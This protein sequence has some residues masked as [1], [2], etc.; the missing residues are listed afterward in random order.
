MLKSSCRQS[1]IT[2]CE[3]PA[4]RLWAATEQETV[5]Q[6]KRH[7]I[8]SK[9]NGPTEFLSNHV[10]VCKWV[11]WVVAAPSLIRWFHAKSF[12][13]LT[14][15]DTTQISGAASLFSFVFLSPF[16]AV[17]RFSTISYHRSTNNQL[18]RR[19]VSREMKISCSLTFS[20][21][22]RFYKDKIAARIN[23]NPAEDP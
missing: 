5:F 2:R 18:N 1:N 9:S 12:S 14:Q 7:P 3:F 17:K 10:A 15:D 22:R 8:K 13:Q 11:C 21:W 16:S 23:G 19:H 6:T 20:K 4:G